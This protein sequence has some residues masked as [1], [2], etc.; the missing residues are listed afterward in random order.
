VTFDID[1]NGILNV[2]AKDKTTNKEQK[3][4]IQNSTNLSDDEVEQM[5]ADAEKHAEEDKAKKELVEAKNHANGVAFEIEKQL[6]DYGDK[7]DKKDKETIEENVKQLKELAQKEDATKEELDKATEATLTSAQKLGEA[8]QKASQAKEA[9][10]APA[11][12]DATDEAK[13]G[14]GK[15]KEKDDKA[16]AEEGE[17]VEE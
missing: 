4:T 15:A 12:D 6:K 2:S 17:V 3:I 13:K 14:K 1:S 9:T 5:K 11:K 7:L 10:E 16:T 8:M